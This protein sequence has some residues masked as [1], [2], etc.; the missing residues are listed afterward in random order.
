MYQTLAN[1]EQESTS[2]S[3]IKSEPMTSVP[4]ISPVPSTPTPDMNQM[5]L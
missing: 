3:T 4:K 2:V 1:R 5:K